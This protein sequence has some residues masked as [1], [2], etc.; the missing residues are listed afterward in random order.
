VGAPKIKGLETLS[1]KPNPLQKYH[2][3]N[4][5]IM[6]H[7]PRVELCPKSARKMKKKM[8]D[9]GKMGFRVFLWEK[10]GK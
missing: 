10:W 9:L 7:N 5:R 8:E 1:N 2:T 3:T 6:G 4:S